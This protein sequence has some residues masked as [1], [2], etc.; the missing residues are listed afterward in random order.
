VNKPGEAGRQLRFSPTWSG[1]AWA[2]HGG[3]KTQIGFESLGRDRLV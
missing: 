2:A 3:D 1:G